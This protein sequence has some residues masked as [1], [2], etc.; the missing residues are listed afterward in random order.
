MNI[1]ICD[2]ELF[3]REELLRYI[4]ESPVSETL[5]VDVYE[6]GYGIIQS[7]VYGN[8][9][10]IVFMDICLGGENGIEIAKSIKD[11]WPKT[12]VIFMSSYQDYYRE[13][14]ETDS[15]GFITKPLSKKNVHSRL[16]QAI[17]RI[18]RTTKRLYQFT[19][20]G[21]T[22]VIDLNEVCYISSFYRFITFKMTNN[23]EHGFYAKLDEVFEEVFEI[24][25]YFAQIHK[26]FI[27]N[28]MHVTNFTKN[29][30]EM[31][32]HILK[33]TPKYYTNFKYKMEYKRLY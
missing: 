23:E 8:M 3:C 25:P 1:A 11:R 6:N 33:I 9:Y 7:F 14:A 22:T 17:D 29:W 2:D 15:F 21:N 20:K 31:G 16:K 24:Y 32:E 10:D 4:K 19:Y 12:L 30:V 18:Y 5:E 28:L 13:V 26:S 27:V